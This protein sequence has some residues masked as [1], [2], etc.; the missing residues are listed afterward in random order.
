M[1]Q[2][3]YKLCSIVLTLAMVLS[4]CVTATVTA[5]AATINYRD[6]VINRGNGLKNTYAK[7]KAGEEV[8]VFYFGGSV[9]VGS[10]A[11]RQ[12]VDSWRA[13]TGKWLQTNFPSSTINNVNVAYGNT[14]S[15]LG[16]YRM[17]VE[18]LPKN[19]DLI[20]IEFSIND[21]YDQISEVDASRQFETIIRT[22]RKQA[23][24]CDIVNV[25]T[26]D[27]GE[28]ADLISDDMLHSQAA[29]HEKIAAAYNVPTLRVGHALV[30]QMYA[31]AGYGWESVWG[32]Y[33]PP[34]LS[35]TAG[36]DIVHPND[37][38]YKVY[39]EVVKEYLNSELKSS[40]YDG[41]I[42]KHIP[43]KLVNDYLLDGDMKYID[44]DNGLNNAS[45]ELG[46]NFT[47]DSSAGSY[48]DVMKG[49][50]KGDRL[51]SRFVIKFTGTELSALYSAE[52]L[53]GFV[54][55][56]DGKDD[57]ATKQKNVTVLV[58]GLKYGEHTV[59]I[60]P[61]FAQ[62]GTTT[63]TFYGFF[64]RNE[65][66]ASNANTIKTELKKEGSKYYYYYDGYKCN[67]T[68]LVKINGTWYYIEKGVWAETVDT[69][70]KINGKWF[71]IKKGIWKATTG[72]VQYKGKTFYVVG[73]KWNS[74]VNDLKKI[75]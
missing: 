67:E 50:V 63:L 22:I 26:T 8:N 3:I 56:V 59:E 31:E 42:T 34:S 28:T 73:G 62:S 40:K 48:R 20:F 38:G 25:L 24:D 27:K 36:Y 9:T 74:S 23:P 44:A 61:S 2:K 11:T 13:L 19:P 14:G 21:K 7:L 45:G 65:N 17:V 1:K 71:L 10:G 68:D 12:D 70:H 37:K 30:D 66:K 33:F 41:K 47:Y 35:G 60:I 32:E 51:T 49:G 6:Y 75:N 4:V 72:L 43:P 46:G 29:A 58:S 69:L 57:F 55:K 52:G 16:L 39:F 53:N 5:A 15:W 54:L 64:T 18:I